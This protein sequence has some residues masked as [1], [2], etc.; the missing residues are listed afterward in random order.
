MGWGGGGSLKNICLQAVNGSFGIAKV[1]VLL[2]K[3][4]EE[5]TDI[6]KSTFY[7]MFYRKRNKGNDPL[8]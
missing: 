2:S 3:K 7:V 6:I 1:D 4:R 8:H 5:K